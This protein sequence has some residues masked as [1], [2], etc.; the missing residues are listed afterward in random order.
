MPVIPSR[1]RP[2]FFLREGHV[3]TILPALWPRRLDV[4]FE[5]ERL[6]LEDGDFLDLDWLRN[7]RGE[8]RDR[9]AWTGGKLG[10][11]LHPRAWPRHCGR[12]DGMCS[13]GIFE[14]AAASRT[15]CCDL[16]TR[17]KRAIWDG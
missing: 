6:E 17:V 14:D 1:F 15:G 5:R 9:V 4:A 7:G 8:A 11:K 12:R 10:W 13:R 2:P 16:I 3:Q